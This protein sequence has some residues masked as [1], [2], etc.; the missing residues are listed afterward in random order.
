MSAPFAGMTRIR[1]L[2]SAAHQPPSQSGQHQTPARYRPAYRRFSSVADPH[3]RLG[4]S[5]VQDRP[6]LDVWKISGALPVSHANP[7]AG[8]TKSKLVPLPLNRQP[9]TTGCHVRPPSVV[10]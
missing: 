7:V 2:R 10:R 3:P 8:L 4:I 1:F 9:W 5:E 6:E